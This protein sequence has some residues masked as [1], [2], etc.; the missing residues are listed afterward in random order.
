MQGKRKCAPTLTGHSP[1]DK[2]C[3]GWYTE[4]VRGTLIQSCHGRYTWSHTE[5]GR[6]GTQASCLPGQGAAHPTVHMG[7]R[8]SQGSR[9]SGW[10]AEGG[11]APAGALSP[12]ALPTYLLSNQEPT[13]DETVQDLLT[14]AVGR[15]AGLGGEVSCGSESQGRAGQS[16]DIGL[17]WVQAS[18]G[19]SSTQ[20]GGGAPVGEA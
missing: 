7:Q 10:E 12:A 2:K 6:G 11:Q 14:V 16:T 17:G 13:L 5:N 3:G 4:N 8:S 1:V 18:T 20:R 19:P 15:L 9:R